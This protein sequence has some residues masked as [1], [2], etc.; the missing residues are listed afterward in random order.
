M[1]EYAN[2]IWHVLDSLRGHAA[3]FDIVSVAEECRKTGI[4]FG[5]DELRFVMLHLGK[6]YCENYLPAGV[7]EFIG[8]LLT[9]YSPKRILDPWAGIGFLPI[10]IYECLQ[11]DQL[12]AISPTVVGHQ[13]VQAVKGTSEISCL[14][15]EP[16]SILASSAG[17][18][19]AVVSCPPFNMQ[20]R[21][22]FTAR[23]GD[24][25]ITVKDDFGNLLI[26]QSCLALSQNGVGIFVVPASFIW[27]R[28]ADDARATLER[29]GIYLTAAIE[30]PAETFNPLTS[31]STYIVLLQRTEDRTVFTAQ[32]SP[33]SK[34]Q[35]TV[36]ANLSTRS[37]GTLASQ[38]RFVPK[39]SFRGFSQVDIAERIALLA[40]RMGL[41]PV[42]F[43]EV[44]L[45]V[46][47]P[48]SGRNFTRFEEKPNSVYLPQMSSTAAT[49]SQDSLPE[50]LKSYFQLVVNTELADAEFLAGFL[51]TSLGHLVRDVVR[52]GAVIPRITK[53]LLQ[54]VHLYL[55]PQDAR[56]LQTQAVDVHKTILR[57]KAELSELESRL[58]QR[59]IAVGKIHSSLRLVNREERFEEWIDSLPFPLASVLWVYHTETGS[60]KERYERALLVCEALAEFMAVVYLSAFNSAASRWSELQPKLMAALAEHK[61]SFE[62]GTFGTWRVVVECLGAEARR[63]LNAERE[64]CFQLFKTRNPEVLETILS[65]RLV[66]L[67]QDANAIRN[68]WSGH[69]GAVSESAAKQVYDKL[70]QHIS[71]VRNVFGTAWEAYELLLPNICKVRGGVFTYSARR[72]MGSRTPFRSIDL[73]LAE[74]MEDGHLHL[75]SPDE[76]RTLKLLPFIKVMPSPKTEENACYFYNRKQGDDIRFLSYYFET[77]SDVVQEFGDTADALN[78]LLSPA[79]RFSTPENQ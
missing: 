63:L 18:Y 54:Q 62:L 8:R 76:T 58:W 7:A 4:P 15:G 9:P 29:A 79:G 38:G 74:G 71:T 75:W 36:L 37:P 69:K 45:E 30:L 41:V 22:P 24:E 33:D 31:I 61:L 3:R 70:S 23:I 2:A 48:S 77:D 11:P 47:S 25:D 26:L 43:T 20:S 44:V 17:V 40:Q 55:P 68:N 67:L 66:G 73:A 27:R 39:D 60:Y 1:T 46:N 49:T 12:V 10:P 32:Y 53:N 51:N 64:V 65:K 28:K 5:V 21:Q 59:P 50:G 14:Q 57:L 13:I 19:D 72:I 78:G 6:E 42:P 35:Q 34:H 52:Q 56:N 16:Q